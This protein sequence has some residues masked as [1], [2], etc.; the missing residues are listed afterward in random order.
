MVD[1]LSC[2]VRSSWRFWSRKDGRLKFQSVLVEQQGL[3]PIT[4]PQQLCT[5][6]HMSHFS[7]ERNNKLYI[8]FETS[9]RWKSRSMSWQGLF[10]VSI[11]LAWF[12]LTEKRYVELLG[13]ECKVKKNVNSFWLR[14]ASC[15]LVASVCTKLSYL[16][17]DRSFIFTVQTCDRFWSRHLSYR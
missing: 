13:I 12:V 17:A 14:Q 6:Q 9:S 10:G 15:S 5:A 8:C 4:A 16:A 3:W 2:Q 1:S 11:I 7:S